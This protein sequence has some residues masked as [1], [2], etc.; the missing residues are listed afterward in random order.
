MRCR[1]FVGVGGKSIGVNASG[2]GVGYVKAS[3]VVGKRVRINSQVSSSA[4]KPGGRAF[5]AIVVCGGKCCRKKGA[6][7][8]TDA[9]NL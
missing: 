6:G 2:M 1:N 8:R 3:S 4:L 9:V 7:A 5:L